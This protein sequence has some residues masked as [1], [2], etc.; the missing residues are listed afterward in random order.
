M[1]GITKIQVLQQQADD[2]ELRAER[3]QLEVEGERRAQGQAKAEMAPLKRRIE[4]VE[5]EVDH[6][7]GTWPLPCKSCRKLRK[8]PMRARKL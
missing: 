6:T 3:L 8:L 4:L 5:E 1:G 7:Q 2:A